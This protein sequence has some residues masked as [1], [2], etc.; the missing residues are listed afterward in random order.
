MR[1]YADGVGVLGPGL[2]GWPAACA[3]LR[4]EAPYAMTEMG[5][6]TADL[7]PPAERRRCGNTVRLALHVGLEAVRHG[8]ARADTLPTVFT[9]SSGDGEVTHHLCTALAR[10][11]R[12]VSP[13]RFHNSVHNAPAGYWSIATEA[14][15]PSTSI[16]AFESSFAAGLLE[17]AL[18]VTAWERPVLL[19]AYDAPYLPPL[20]VLYPM[21]APFGVALLLAP[22]PGTGSL[23][24]VAIELGPPA[25]ETQLADPALE[26]LRRG[27]AAARSLPLLG[28]LARGEPARAE[29]GYLPEMGIS[30]GVAPCP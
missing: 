14:R 17:A 10:P 2:D 6:P 21:I 15:E 16:C 4:G 12:D 28:A 19:V 20:D 25:G 8:G 9:S 27:V 13:T 3:V 5:H 22:A 1:V 24:S 29:L 30:V 11:E 18:Q 23:G 7:L 26:R